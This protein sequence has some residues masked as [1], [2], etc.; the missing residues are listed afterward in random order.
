MSA[1]GDLHARNR[2]VPRFVDL[3]GKAGRTEKPFCL[4][5]VVGKT[6]SIAFTAWIIATGVKAALIAIGFG[7]CACHTLQQVV[8][9][10]KLQHILVKRLLAASCGK[11]FICNL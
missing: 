8:G 11:A 2:L 10:T 7:K 6:A 1:E 9:Q 5:H 3:R 4:V